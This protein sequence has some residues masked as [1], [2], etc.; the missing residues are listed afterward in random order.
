MLLYTK[1]SLI[2]R[3]KVCV[4]M[5]QMVK[6]IIQFLLLV[7]VTSLNS[8]GQNKYPKNYFRS[9]LDIPLFLSGNFGEIRTNHFHTGL[10]LKTENREGL[11]I[12]AAAEG[13]VSRIKVS[14][15]GYGKAIYI[16]HP[17]GYVTVYAHLSSFKGEIDNYV[18]EAQRLNETF[19]IELLPK[20][21]L[22][23]VKKGEVIGLSGN[24]GSSQGPH[25]HFEVRDEKTEN[26]IN[27]LF[28]GFDIKD[29]S[30]PEISLLAVYLFDQNNNTTMKKF[31][32]KGSNGKY[33][34][35]NDQ[36][37]PVSDRV[38]FGIE[39]IDRELAGGNRNGAFS[40]ELKVNEK[41]VFLSELEFLSFDNNRAIN[42]HIDYIEKKTKGCS[43]QKCFLKE[44]NKLP[45]YKEVNNKGYIDLDNDSV[46][47]VKYNVKDFFGNT[48]SLRFKIKRTPTLSIPPTPKPTNAI[49]FRCNKPNMLK[50]D[51][52]VA[53]FPDEVFYE[54]IFF[55]YSKSPAKSYTIAPVYNLHDE[56][57]PLRKAFSLSIKVDTNV[58]KVVKEKGV[59][60]SF[61]NDK[62][63]SEA[64]IY[65][66][67]FLTAQ[68]KN[69]GKYSVMLDTLAPEL[70][71]IN[72]SEGKNLTQANG[73]KIKVSDNLSGIKE[74]KAYIDKKWVLMEYD[75]KQKSLFHLFED[76]LKKGKHLF[77]LIV[78]DHKKNTVFYK[79]E[80][81]K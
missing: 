49:F 59:I 45:I 64:T 20:K 76:D 53:E 66:N 56:M 40:I 2:L 19:E 62:A 39:T 30:K 77:E 8:F 67:G 79:A 27:P 33:Y 55:S 47:E 68:L 16:T 72:I 31:P 41:P 74:F 71:P 25:L 17:N 7:S 37:I 81:I 48:S 21:D 10:D 18:K 51:E 14:P 11:K 61:H 80:F 54:D 32:V 69:L 70:T 78:T 5:N 6:Q 73:I 57:T 9:P 42:C 24:T 28:F 29:N 15:Y 75:P 60:V 65:K 3:Y 34:L 1:P 35:P 36:V 63:V 52:I 22:L 50:E 38:G 13:Y 44:T 58:H 23:S 12:Y 4:Q 43:I 26:P 46:Q